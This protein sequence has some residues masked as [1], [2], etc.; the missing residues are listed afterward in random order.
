[1]VTIRVYFPK[2][3][4]LLIDSTA[5]KGESVAKH[6][7]VNFIMQ[8]QSILISTFIIAFIYHSCA[9]I[10]PSVISPNGLAEKSR[11]STTRGGSTNS[12]GSRYYPYCNVSV[13][14]VEK[15]RVEVIEEECCVACTAHVVF[16]GD[17]MDH[18]MTSMNSVLLNTKYPHKLA[19][20]AFSMTDPSDDVKSKAMRMRKH[21]ATVCFH[22]FSY[23]D[24]ASYIN[25][26][27]VERKAR[28][29]APE[30]YVRFILP[31]RLP[32]ARFCMWMD[33][34]IITMVDIVEFMEHHSRSEAAVGGYVK[35]RKSKK[36][37]PVADEYRKRG[38]N[39]TG[40]DDTFNAGVLHMN[41][42]R[43]RKDSI[44]ACIKQINL[45]NERENLY[46][47]YGSQMPLNILFGG[48]RFHRLGPIDEYATE[49]GSAF[50][51]SYSKEEL[52]VIKFMHWSGDNKPWLSSRHAFHADIWE[53][54]S[55]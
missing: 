27:L 48:A 1:M 8:L 30:N 15:Q 11:N 36:I 14:P 26:V 34:D 45:I 40:Q 42:D 9:V 10:S 41:L 7:L 39:V 31:E 38:F 25:T 24:V 54:Y 32:Y 47:T 52:S 6:N 51:R 13:L 28:L 2:V 12:S 46:N 5:V 3:K 17:Q 19:L 43:W 49:I 21:G 50:G 33:I 44:G 55:L 22:K 23:D 53:K 20:H 18:M 29:K 4:I 37:L 35:R 16:A